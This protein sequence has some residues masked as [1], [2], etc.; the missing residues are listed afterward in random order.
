MVDKYEAQKKRDALDE[1]IANATQIE[2]EK[3]WEE[4]VSKEVA[5]AKKRIEEEI[6]KRIKKGEQPQKVIEE[7]ENKI[8]P[9]GTILKEEREWMN[10]A[11]EKAED[12]A[13][14]TE[15]VRRIEQNPN[16][17]RD[18][19]ELYKVVAARR[20]YQKWNKKGMNARN[21]TVPRLV[22]EAE[23]EIKKWGP[24]EAIRGPEEQ[25]KVTEYNKKREKKRGAK[26]G[27][28]RRRF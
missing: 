21:E 4:R 1:I 10:Q 7:M 26:R 15:Q 27:S 14:L 18:K 3:E 28:R 2:W 17:N 25:E 13:R 22:K 8:L 20:V 19:K 11:I 24:L 23:K 9:N 6:E 16:L 12:K 5:E